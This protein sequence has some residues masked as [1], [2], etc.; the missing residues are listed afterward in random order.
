MN[1]SEQ[2]PSP[3]PFAP[4]GA[5]SEQP[6]VETLSASASGNNVD[7]QGSAV[8]AKPEGHAAEEVPTKELDELSA[9]E[10]EKW[11]ER[12]QT[13]NKA[14][15][16]ILLSYPEL[17]KKHYSA[18]EISDKDAT[19][20][21]LV[22]SVRQELAGDPEFLG[23]AMLYMEGIRVGLEQFLVARGDRPYGLPEKGDR[24][25]NPYKNQDILVEGTRKERA[26]AVGGARP[27]TVA[28]GYED[29]R[30]V[31]RDPGR[32]FFQKGVKNLDVEADLLTP[33]LDA[34]LRSFDK[35]FTGKFNKIYN[36]LKD[37]LVGAAEIIEDQASQGEEFTEG[38]NAEIAS[39]GELGKRVQAIHAAWEP[40][41]VEEHISPE[42]VHEKHDLL[43]QL[44]I[45]VRQFPKSW[46]R[47]SKVLEEVY[48]EKQ[49]KSE[50][51]PRKRRTGRERTSVNDQSNE[52]PS[53]TGR[54][55]KQSE[56]RVVKKGQQPRGGRDETVLDF[57]AQG[58]KELTDREIW[59]QFQKYRGARYS[60]ERWW[61][62][63]RNTLEQR[64]REIRM[65][66]QD[67]TQMA[68]LIDKL[69]KRRDW[70]KAMWRL[71][72]EVQKIALRE[73]GDDVTRDLNLMEE[74]K[75][76]VLSKSI[77]FRKDEEELRFLYDYF[78]RYLAAL[79]VGER[80][81]ASKLSQSRRRKVQVNNVD[82]TDS[83]IVSLG[84]E[85]EAEAIAAEYAIAKVAAEHLGERWFEQN[86][87]VQK[88]L[89]E[90][91]RLLFGE[92]DM[93]VAEAQAFLAQHG[94]PPE[95]Q[96]AIIASQLSQG[97]NL[98]VVRILESG[99]LPSTPEAIEGLATGLLE[100]QQLKR[101]SYD[102]AKS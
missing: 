68:E 2:I 19:Y 16:V 87:R 27:F 91:L 10:R 13:A 30:G 97:F 15:E 92:K 66:Q 85:T 80:V 77:D 81:I 88:V 18:D 69:S 37:L 43:L 11:L 96:L 36:E 75:S 62:D 29:E 99:D 76:R 4:T 54:Y 45:L 52:G 95:Q 46:I 82:S 48:K 64:I 89:I 47:N 6:L 49:S 41:G 24:L 34:R 17:L 100:Q 35:Q 50:R 79:Q 84:K 32:P 63:K 22:S 53:Q 71:G 74:R 1:E 7:E 31:R 26:E 3:S 39:I 70:G 101:L 73:T 90:K 83:N 28:F 20:E 42:G 23:D 40:L 57:E 21:D 78:F 59:Q 9:E 58:A 33:N 102:K 44:E 12:Y 72:P 67:I 25:H 56:D 8:P 65:Q 86:E 93:D 5:A 51:K 98:A 55:R 60:A 38:S 14:V 61:R 94:Y